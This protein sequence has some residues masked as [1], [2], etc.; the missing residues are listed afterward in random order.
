MASATS[1]GDG[2]SLPEPRGGFSD[3]VDDVNRRAWA[4]ADGIDRFLDEGWTDPGERAAIGHVAAEMANRTILDIGVGAGRTVPLLTAISDDYV[5]IDYTE[6]LVDL[7][8]TRHPGRCIA[9]GDARDLSAF[10]DGSVDLAVFSY[11]GIDAVDPSGRAAVLRAVHRVLRPGGAFVVSVHNRAGPGFGETPWGWFEFTANPVRLGWRVLNLAKTLA[12]GLPNYLR[13]RS[14]SRHGEGYSMLP[15]AAHDFGIVIVY[16]DL[17]EQLRQFAMAGFA[18]EAVY[19]NEHGEP[20]AATGDAGHAW[21]FHF[22][23]RK[24]SA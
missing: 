1:C 10:A 12:T 5:A 14:L 18:V 22:V 15:A 21:W 3:S 9:H 11:N 24:P 2:P 6:A 16:T 8:R 7:C 4:S 20:V 13:N 17:A 23:V 19:D